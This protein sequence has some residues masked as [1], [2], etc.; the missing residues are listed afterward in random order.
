MKDSPFHPIG[1]HDWIDYN[2]IQ[3]DA[4]NSLHE[5]DRC[6][7]EQFASIDFFP[8]YCFKESVNY[9]DIEKKYDY[10]EFANT[11]HDPLKL[12]STPEHACVCM[13]KDTCVTSHKRKYLG[14]VGKGGSAPTSM[15]ETKNNNNNKEQDRYVQCATGGLWQMKEAAAKARGL[16]EAEAGTNA[17]G[18]NEGISGYKA[19]KCEDIKMYSY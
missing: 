4:S 14:Y 7:G 15:H 10:D 9:K 17:G 13:V 12:Y 6:S 1:K 18:R 8:A 19:V 3:K 2:R 11:Q 16:R 5:K